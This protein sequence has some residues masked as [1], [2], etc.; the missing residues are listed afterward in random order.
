[1]KVFLDTNVFVYGLTRPESNSRK[2]LELAESGKIEVVVSEL[3]QREVVRVFRRIA[4]DEAAYNSLNYLRRIAHIIPRRKINRQMIELRGK[5]KE[6][7]LENIATTR[8]QKLKFLVSYDKDYAGFKE[9]VTPKEFAKIMGLK[10]VA[11]EY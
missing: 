4:D 10:P 8:Q 9:Y 2:I 7:D 6:K 5:I 3:V 11:T 1:M